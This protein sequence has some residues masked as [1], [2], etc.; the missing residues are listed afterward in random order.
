MSILKVVRD[1]SAKYHS[2]VMEYVDNVEW[3]ALYPC[4]TEVDIKYYIFQLLQ[5]RI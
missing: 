1:S 4:L 2:L 5:A 3:K